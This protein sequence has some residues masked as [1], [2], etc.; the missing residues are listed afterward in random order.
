MNH[1][2]FSSYPIYFP[3]NPSQ[4]NLKAKP[5]KI[6]VYIENKK[7]VSIEKEPINSKRKNKLTNRNQSRITV[8]LFRVARIEEVTFKQRSE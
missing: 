6:R 1:S 4:N 2:L 3:K 8:R 5:L 7:R